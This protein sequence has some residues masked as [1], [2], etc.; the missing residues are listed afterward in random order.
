MTASIFL[1]FELGQQWFEYRNHSR[2]FFRELID[3]FFI[4]RLVRDDL[5]NTAPRIRPLF[6]LDAR[7][8]FVMDFE[9]VRMKVRQERIVRFLV[10][11]QVQTHFDQP[12]LTA[13]PHLVMQFGIVV[14]QFDDAKE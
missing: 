12:L 9:R 5:M 1:F 7:S 4:E 3:Q 6:D 13:H 14:G 11:F 2:Q 10:C 8:Q